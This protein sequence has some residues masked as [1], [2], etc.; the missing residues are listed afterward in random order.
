MHSE[1][2]PGPIGESH[3][4]LRRM[5]IRP[6]VTAPQVVTRSPDRATPPDRRSPCSTRKGD[7]R[8]EP[9]ALSKRL[10]CSVVLGLGT[11]EDDCASNAV[12]PCPFR[13]TLGQPTND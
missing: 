1:G 7:L 4:R 12:F 10:P 5:V 2:L 3:G 9:V 11:S 6:T 8:S 13:S